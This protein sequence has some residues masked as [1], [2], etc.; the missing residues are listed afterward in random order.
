MRLAGTAELD[1]D[2]TVG[3]ATPGGRP[4]RCPGD[5]RLL[6]AL[7]LLQGRS[8]RRATGAGSVHLHAGIAGG[9]RRRWPVRRR[10]LFGPERAGPARGEPALRGVHGRARV[11]E[12][13]IFRPRRRQA[14]RPAWRF[15]FG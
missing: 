11:S 4:N 5:S 10:V 14:R 6:A 13:L 3:G 15:A 7:D 12:E 9:R 2:A 8:L 1:A